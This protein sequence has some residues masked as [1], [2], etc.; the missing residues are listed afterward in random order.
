V[1]AQAQGPGNDPEALGRDVA[2]QL[3][4]GGAGELLR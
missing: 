2:R 1:R 3:L 4:D